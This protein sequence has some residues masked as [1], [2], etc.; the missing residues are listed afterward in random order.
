[1]LDGAPQPFDKTIVMVAAFAVRTDLNTMALQYLDKCR[2][3]K[4]NALVGIHD[5][6]TT[7]NLDRRIQCLHT[8]ICAHRVE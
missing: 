4:Q 7:V 1:M 8:E 6:R 2:T 3:G 5:P